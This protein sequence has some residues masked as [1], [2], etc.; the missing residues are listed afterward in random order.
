MKAWRA[1]EKAQAE[2][3]QGFVWLETPQVILQLRKQMEAKAAKIA[4][5]KPSEVSQRS[6]VTQAEDMQLS[7]PSQSLDT[8]SR[9]QTV[10]TEQQLPQAGSAFTSTYS[11]DDFS[12]MDDMAM[13]WQRWDTLLNSF[14][15]PAQP[16]TMNPAQLQFLGQYGQQGYSWP[17]PA[18]RAQ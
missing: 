9:Q 10:L 16:A 14:D 13:D 2:N 1:R 5:A 8:P 4:E 7:A 6:L 17:L 15:M 11:P 12:V 18:Y 3:S